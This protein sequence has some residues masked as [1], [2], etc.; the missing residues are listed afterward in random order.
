MLFLSNFARHLRERA[1]KIFFFFGIFEIFFENSKIDV[2]LTCYSA[3]TRDIG[4][5][6]VR[7]KKNFEFFFYFFEKNNTKLDQNNA[8][9]DLLREESRDLAF[10]LYA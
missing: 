7:K 4:F 10:R 8:K 1:R 9:L 6:R 5:I 2:N 3:F